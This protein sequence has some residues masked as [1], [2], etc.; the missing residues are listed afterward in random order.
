MMDSL[1]QVREFTDA[2]LGCY[3]SV[4]HAG[5]GY[6]LWPIGRLATASIRSVLRLTL[7]AC[8]SWRGKYVLRLLWLSVSSGPS[9][10]LAHESH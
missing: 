9:L 10:D 8:G 4:L 1:E 6:K 7:T 2:Y 5:R 3:A